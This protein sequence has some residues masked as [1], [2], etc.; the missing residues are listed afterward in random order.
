M[1]AILSHDSYA[2]N[3]SHGSNFHLFRSGSSLHTNNMK[4]KKEAHLTSIDNMKGAVVL[5]FGDSV[6]AENQKKK[7]N[8]SGLQPEES[9]PKLNKKMATGTT[10]PNMP[11][12]P[13]LNM[14]DIMKN[15]DF[16]IDNFE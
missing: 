10:N 15:I 1:T 6:R 11:K 9:K 8:A 12:A 14:D 16:K 2:E 7:V 13:Q 3:K 4:T 5:G